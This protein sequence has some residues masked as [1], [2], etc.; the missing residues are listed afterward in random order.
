MTGHINDPRRMGRKAVRPYPKY[1]ALCCIA[2]AISAVSAGTVEQAIILADPQMQV[3][4]GVVRGCGYRLKAIPQSF[5]GRSPVLALDASFNLYLDGIG[6]LKGGAVHSDFKGGT[7]QPTTRPIQNFWLKVQG[8]KPTSAADGKVLASDT[9]GYLLYAAS[10]DSVLALYRSVAAGTPLTV[11]V[12]VKGEGVDRIY[13]GI[14]Q[15]SDANRQQGRQCLED[16]VKEAGTA[17][18]SVRPGR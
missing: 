13:T 17:A 6:L 9:P 16:L 1:W 14:V 7:P 12:R 8:D 10:V 3:K 11:G 15:I 2:S 4:D 18:T 5:D